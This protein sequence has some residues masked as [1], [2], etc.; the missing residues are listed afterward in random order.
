M[1]TPRGV[2]L[3]GCYGN[4]KATTGNGGLWSI[5]ASLRLLR[6]AIIGHKGAVKYILYVVL[7]MWL[8]FG[9]VSL[10]GWPW[11]QQHQLQ[12]G[13]HYTTPSVPPSPTPKILNSVANTCIYGIS[14][15][16]F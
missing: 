3:R 11:Q 5:I 4:Q 14:L 13:K 2:E 7:A 9:W 1:T 8:W 16:L 12:Q 15:F 6:E 10:L